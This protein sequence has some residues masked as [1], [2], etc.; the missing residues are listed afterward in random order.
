MTATERWPD[1]ELTTYTIYLFREGEQW[2]VYYEYFEDNWPR[3]N[4]TA[5]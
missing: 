5:L 3:F 2:G 1:I 4:G